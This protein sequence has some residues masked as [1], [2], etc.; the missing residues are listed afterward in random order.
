MSK[1]IKKNGAAVLKTSA[2]HLRV[3]EFLTSAD[4]ELLR[5]AADEQV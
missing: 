2:K 1:E 3:D 4:K 5:E